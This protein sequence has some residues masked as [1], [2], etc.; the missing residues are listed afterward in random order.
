[1]ELLLRKNLDVVRHMV[2]PDVHKEGDAP[3]IPRGLP[4][5]ELVGDPMEV[6]PVERHVL[7]LKGVRQAVCPKTTNLVT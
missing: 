5:D 2:E 4:R 7:P 3:V 6:P 1:M